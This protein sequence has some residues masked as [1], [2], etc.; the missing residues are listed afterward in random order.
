[1]SLPSRTSGS[2]EK[3][4]KRA[5]IKLTC[6]AIR[7]Q[8]FRLQFPDLYSKLSP[9]LPSQRH[10]L[11]KKQLQTR[12]VKLIEK[13]GLVPQCPPATCQCRET[14]PDFNLDR[15]GS[16]LA[17][18]ISPYNSHIIVHTLEKDWPS[19][20]SNGRD[21]WI[22]NDLKDLVKPEGRVWRAAQKRDNVSSRPS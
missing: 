20:I 13:P 3:F 18:T 8:P 17:R 21:G 16:S 5:P 4:V 14:P 15:S 11:R 2:I 7:S 6:N 9:T 22:A 10:D 19:N 1:M 12:Q